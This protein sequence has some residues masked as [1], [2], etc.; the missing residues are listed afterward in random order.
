MGAGPNYPGRGLT[1]RR[2]RACVEHVVPARDAASKRAGEGTPRNRTPAVVADDDVACRHGVALGLADRSCRQQRTA[3]WLEMLPA[4]P[5]GSVMAVD[6]GFV[7]YEYTARPGQPASRAVAGRLECPPAEKA[8]V[9]PRAGQYGL[10]LAG[11]GGQ[12]ARTPARVAAGGGSH[13]PTSGVSGDSV[14]S[15]RDLTD[16]QVVELY[17][18]RWGIELFYRHLKQTFQ[19]RKLRSARAEMRI[20]VGVVAGRTLGH[21]ALCAVANRARDLPPPRLS[22][23]GTLRAFRR[24][25]RDYL[26]PRERGR[27]LCDALRKAVVDDYPRGPKTSRD[28]PR[29]KQERPPAAPESSTLRQRNFVGQNY[30]S[31][32]RSK[33]VNGECHPDAISRSSVRLREGPGHWVETIGY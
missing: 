7:G 13:R 21:G 20:R 18:R 8:G 10:S 33:R 4:L 24:V 9:C 32:E 1:K 26:H 25:L 15:T 27:G 11:S 31:T 16:Q 30:F 5:P 19:R 28:Y 17:A 22:I 29:K 14:L 6:A 3:H 12:A 2:I 23:A